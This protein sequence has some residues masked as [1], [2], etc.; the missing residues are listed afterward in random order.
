MIFVGT[1]V[2][3]GRGKAVV[4]A[5][6][7]KTEF[8]KIA[9][10]VQEAEEEET[11]LQKR[12]DSFARKIA[13]VVILVCIAIFA[14]ASYQGIL[15]RLLAPWRDPRLVFSLYG[16][17]SQEFVPLHGRIRLLDQSHILSPLLV[18]GAW[19]RFVSQ[20]ALELFFY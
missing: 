19:C 12:L 6:G 15:A 2:I 1:H 9:E 18:I 8:G 17:A 13:K 7:M 11:P 10:L 3:Y 16:L 5:T 14:L 4:T 20:V